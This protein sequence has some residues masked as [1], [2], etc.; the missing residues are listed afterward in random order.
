M[1]TPEMFAR[2]PPDACLF[3][4]REL[5]DQAI[6]DVTDDPQDDWPRRERICVAVYDFEHLVE[7]FGGDDD[8][9]DN[10]SYNV[11]GSWLGEGT[12]VIRYPE[13]PDE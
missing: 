11:A 3:E 4:P 12:P 2:L 1:L 13:N 7:L 8:A 10:V 9:L 5:L 6:V